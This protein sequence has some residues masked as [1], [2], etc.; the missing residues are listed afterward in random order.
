MQLNNNKF[1]LLESRGRSTPEMEVRREVLKHVYGE[2]VSIDHAFSFLEYLEWL[3]A[4]AGN[5]LNPHHAPQ[6]TPLYH[7]LHV[8]HFRLE[9]FDVQAHNLELE[10]AL[11][12]SKTSQ[13]LLSSGHHREKAKTRKKKSLAFLQSKVAL[14]LPRDYPLPQ[15]S[16]KLLTGTPMGELVAEIFAEDLSLYQSLT[17][18]GAMISSLQR[19]LGIFQTH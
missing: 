4:N 9:D 2:E 17:L 10:F 15:I 19:F 13:E 12:T 11:P 3:K 1:Q 5:K 14:D 16:E 7:L 18:D 8:R 6:H